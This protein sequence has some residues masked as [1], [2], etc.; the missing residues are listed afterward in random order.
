MG[1]DLDMADSAIWRS[2]TIALLL[3]GLSLG[4]N[5]STSRLLGNF[6]SLTMSLRNLDL[7]EGWILLSSTALL[8]IN[9]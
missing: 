5:D 6:T 7:V 2:T 8:S 9:S 1:L 4:M 3:V